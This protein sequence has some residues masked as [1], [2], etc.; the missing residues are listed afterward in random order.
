[1]TC[2]T[3]TPSVAQSSR[4]HRLLCTVEAPFCPPCVARTLETVAA[5]AG[6]RPVARSVAG[7]LRT[8]PQSRHLSSGNQ[9]HR[10]Q[11]ATDHALPTPVP[12]A[13]R[14]A[15]RPWSVQPFSRR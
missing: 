14:V 8:H 5:I 13:G 10:S 9:Q 6:P 11:H 12:H 15:Q 7:S 3:Q 2:R 1:M 4:Q